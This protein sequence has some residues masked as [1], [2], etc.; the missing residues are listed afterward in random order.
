MKDCRSDPH[1][2]HL[3]GQRHSTA[4]GRVGGSALH[5]VVGHGLYLQKADHIYKNSFLSAFFYRSVRLASAHYPGQLGCSVPGPLREDTAFDC[6]RYT[7][8]YF[9]QEIL[10]LFP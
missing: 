5:G 6:S 10:Q 8:I 9:G 4:A 7:Q 1:R 2:S 3:V